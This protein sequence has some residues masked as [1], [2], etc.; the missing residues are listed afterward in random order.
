VALPYDE[1]LLLQDEEGDSE[2]DPQEKMIA[3]E[4]HRFLHQAL[5]ELSGRDRQLIALAFFRGPTHDEIVHPAAI[6]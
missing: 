4:R 2:T 1:D 6:P 3:Q 5:A